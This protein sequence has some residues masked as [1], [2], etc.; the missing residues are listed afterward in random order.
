MDILNH[1]LYIWY[2]HDHVSKERN[3]DIGL[4][5]GTLEKQ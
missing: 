2:V 3:L 5:V 4:E 1:G